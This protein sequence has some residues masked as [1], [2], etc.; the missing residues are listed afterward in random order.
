MKVLFI[1]KSSNSKVGRLPVTI[2]ESASCPKTCPHINGNCYAKTGPQSWIW[3]KV[4]KG[5]AGKNL[6][7]WDGL[8]NNI[9]ALPAGQ[10]WRM[11]TSG[12]IPH[13]DGLIRLD[14]LKQLIEA[15]KG[16]KGW[17][18]SHHILNT[19]N[20]EALKSATAKGFTI[21]ASTETLSDADAAMNK[22]LNACS[23]ISSDNPHLIAYSSLK[24]RK[25]YYKVSQ[26]IKTP[27]GR[28][29]VVCPAQTCQPTKCET[30]LLC[31]KPRDYAIAFVAHGNNKKKLNQLLNQST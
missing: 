30:C 28:R 22:G 1:K 25:T 13:F 31:S 11:N 9:K 29:V 14:L 7:D 12:D 20:T 8:A 27:A 15:N 3:S 2:T 16:R 19:H 26:P 5:T 4:D 21:N 6:T 17:T 18:Y 24:D 10:P 23:I